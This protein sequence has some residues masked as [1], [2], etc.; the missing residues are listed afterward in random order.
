MA[1]ISALVQV[2]FFLAQLSETTARMERAAMSATTELQATAQYVQALLVSARGTTETV[3]RSAVEQMGY[4]EA[5]GRRSARTLA[6]LELLITHTDARMERITQTLEGAS[7]SA[8]ENLVQIGSLAASARG[9]LHELTE[10]SIEL[11]E[12]STATIERAEERLADGRL[13]QIASSLAV[14]SENAAQATA[15]VAEATGYVRDI[16]SPQRKGFWRR[17]LELLIPRPTVSVP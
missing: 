9:D 17:L 3:R 1:A 10:E 12:A 8:Q 15:H 13:D 7:T 4:Y 11:I 14:T 2:T 6:R 5:I 16:L